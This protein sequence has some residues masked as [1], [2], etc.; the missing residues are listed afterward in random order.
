MVYKKSEQLKLLITAFEPFNQQTENASLDVLNQLPNELKGIQVIKLV[1]PVVYNNYR[2]SLF[3]D[4]YS[5]DIIIHLGEAGG[6]HNI[7]LERRAINLMNASIPD[8]EGNIK[9]NQKIFEN[10]PD[11][12]LTNIDIDTLVLNLIAQ[13]YPI[14]VSESAGQYICNQAF[15]CS[16]HELKTRNLPVKV[17]F[18]H[19]PRLNHQ[20]NQPTTPTLSLEIATHSVEAIIN[21]ITK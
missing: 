21:E 13:K 12:Y 14:E 2:Y 19:I 20:I 16:M 7:N 15:Y 18:I 10:G 17:G 9:F 8:N 11:E 6:R 5:P 1:L 4:R 3:I